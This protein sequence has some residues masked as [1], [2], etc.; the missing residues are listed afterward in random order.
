[1]NQIRFCFKEFENRETPFLH[2]NKGNLQQNCKAFKMAFNKCQVFY[3]VKA[4]STDSV[5]SIINKE[6]LNF[7]VASL[8]E[9]NKLKRLDVNPSRI[10]FSAPTKLPRD[11]LQAYRYGILTYAFDSE[12]ELLKLSKLA[13]GATVVARLAVD[14]EGSRWPLTRKFGLS[15]EQAL[16]CILKSKALGLH[17]GGVTF[18][19]GSQNLE[20]TT[21]ERALDRAWSVWFELKKEGI[22]TD[23]INIGGGFPVK[24]TENVPSVSAIARIVIKYTKKLFGKEV[25]IYVEPGR[26]LVASSGTLYASVVNRARRESEEWLYVDVGVFNGLQETLEGF[27]YNIVAEKNGNLTPYILCGSTCDSMDRIASEVMLPD[28]LEIGDRLCFS[29]AGAYT[30]SYEYYNGFKYP[31]TIIK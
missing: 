7:D 20:P 14:N 3:S 17:F 9:I 26:S 8:G 28:N 24:Y 31:E 6:E 11:V 16:H 27:R 10:I 21:W 5:L 30:T 22:G 12:A 1:M 29:S 25:K 23:F 2:I 19:V 18:H 15:N 4:N 13:P